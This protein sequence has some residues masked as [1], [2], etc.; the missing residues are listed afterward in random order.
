MIHKN[1]AMKSLEDVDVDSAVEEHVPTSSITTTWR[2]R[3]RQKRSNSSK[4]K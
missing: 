1:D 2:F 3:L 4:M